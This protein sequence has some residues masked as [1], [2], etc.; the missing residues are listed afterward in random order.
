MGETER[1]IRWARVNKRVHC[2]YRTHGVFTHFLIIMK[3]QDK[4][5]FILLIIFVL[6]LFEVTSLL[7]EKHGRG[8]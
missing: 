5:Y 1:D 3:I 8:Y 6:A 4:L 2:I 7:I